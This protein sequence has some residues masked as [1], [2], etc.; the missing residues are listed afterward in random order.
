M[1][2]IVCSNKKAGFSLME[3]LVY[4][5]V[6]AVMATVIVSVFL[7]ITKGR[8]KFISQSEVNSNLRFSMEKINQDI[9]YASNVAVPDT[10]GA[11]SSSLEMT[12]GSDTVR[13]CISNGKLRRQ[14]NGAC[15]DSS[16]TV[17][18][19]KVV[20]TSLIFKRLHNTNSS[21]TPPITAVSIQTSITVAYM[22][23][24]SDF[25]Y[26]ATKTTTELLP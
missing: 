26:S 20:A 12:V 25:Q 13:Y 18:N 22:G 10:A 5:A 8:G 3:L 16:E 11:S 4:T 1:K 9:R 15:G 23:T 24:S 6:L 19:D 7:G 14:I 2:Y 21:F 17:T